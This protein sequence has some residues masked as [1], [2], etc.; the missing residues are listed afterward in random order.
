MAGCISLLR[1]VEGYTVVRGRGKDE[2][3]FWLRENWGW[4]KGKLRRGE[5]EI[6]SERKHGNGKRN[7]EGKVKSRDVRER[8]DVNLK[9]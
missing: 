9:Q 6:G 5:R 7:G 3:G 4:N 2:G 8:R 1:G